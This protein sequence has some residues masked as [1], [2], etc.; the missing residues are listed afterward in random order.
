[1]AFEAKKQARLVI[2]LFLC[3]LF[4]SASALVA[5]PKHDP[6]LIE[7]LSQ[8]R[9]LELEGLL[10]RQTTGASS[11][12]RFTQGVF[13]NRKNQIPESVR[14][15]KP[16]LSAST[17]KLTSEEEQDAFRTLADDY[18]KEFRYADAA[19]TLS[20]LLNR[21][22]RSLSESDRQDIEGDLSTLDLLRHAPPE[23]VSFAGPLDVATTRNRIGLVEIPVSVNGRTEPW[24][25]DTGANISLLIRSRAEALGLTL[26][27]ETTPVVVFSGT[28]VPCHVSLIPRLT[29]GRATIRDVAVLVMED[30]DYYIAQIH[31]QIEALLGYPVLSALGRITFYSDG[32]F[33]ADGPNGL[34]VN[35]GSQMFMEQ[36]TPVVA[37]DDGVATRLFTL[38][39]GAANTYLTAKYLSDHHAEFAV[40]K[41]STVEMAGHPHPLPAYYA[42]HVTL[43]LGGVVVHLEH[44]PV[45]AVPTGSGEDYF[46]GNLGQDVFRQFRSYTLDFRSMRFS[47]TR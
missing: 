35:T 44:V 4:A 5:S 43:T 31:F 28:T 21:L 36:L 39:T 34:K 9:Y 17:A 11:Q 6:N 29:I 7:L 13:A 37:A 16:L 3:I 12:T 46:Y 8:K 32:R 27:T 15:L 41:K 22:G 2:L 23:K 14:L 38:D 26:S 42:E 1:V 45:L 24:P 33:G 18:A 47:A 30:K 10:K 19:N 20:A 25:L 40:A